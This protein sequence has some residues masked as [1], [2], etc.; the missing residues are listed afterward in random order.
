MVLVN[1]LV[2][3]GKGA[4]FVALLA[5]VTCSLISRIEYREVLVAILV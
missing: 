3:G 4:I 5:F 2:Q 1:V